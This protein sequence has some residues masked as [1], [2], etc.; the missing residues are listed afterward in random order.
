VSAGPIYVRIKDN[1]GAWRTLEI[2]EQIWEASEAVTRWM[3]K[4]GVVQF[5]E[6]QRRAD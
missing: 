2:P 5:R 6:L 4:E 3:D 1:K